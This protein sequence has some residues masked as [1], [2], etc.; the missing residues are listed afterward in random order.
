MASS[1]VA[2]P[3]SLT[4]SKASFILE[5]SS[6]NK[7]RGVFS[8]RLTYLWIGSNKWTYSLNPFSGF[9]F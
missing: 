1:I 9:T 3:F 7:I 2:K 5:M 8:N 6:N 4:E